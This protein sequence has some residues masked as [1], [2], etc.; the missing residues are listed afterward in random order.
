MAEWKEF[1][2]FYTANFGRLT[3]S[4]GLTEWAAFA[5]KE[6]REM[7]ILREAMQPLVDRFAAALDNMEPTPRRPTLGQVRKAYY[8]QCAR[9][10]AERELHRYGA[11]TVCGVCGGK[12]LLF[13]LAPLAGDEERRRWPED[14]R[15][16]PW[17]SYRGVELAKCPCC[18]GQISPELRHRIESHGLPLY[19]RPDHPDWPGTLDPQRRL[20]AIEGDKAMIE[21]M[22]MYQK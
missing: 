13:V 16:V 17:R 2:E 21:R 15:S 20:C 4:D 6:V 3:E 5:K 8:A 1:C 19:I 10:K 14:F 12:G 22:R 9:R 7:E 11:G 18:S